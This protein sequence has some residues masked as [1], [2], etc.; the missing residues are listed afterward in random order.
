MGGQVMVA[1]SQEGSATSGSVGLVLSG[2]GARGAY[3]AGALS[4]LLP[5]LTGPD[6]PRVI[7]GSSAGALNAALLASVIDKGVAKAAEN[8]LEAWRRITL[9][10]V[11]AAPRR[12]VVTAATW[13]F[14]H[15]PRTASGLLD[16]TP[17]EKT[18]GE[19]VDTRKI[20]QNV[21]SGLLDSLGIV[22]SS[23]SADDAVVFVEGSESQSP[24][25]GQVRYITTKL[26]I[27]HLLASSAF[28]IAFPPRW[29]QGS[30]AD[31]WYIDGGVHLNTPMKPAID[32]GADR[33]LVLTGTPILSAAHRPPHGSPS[34]GLPPDVTDGNGQI[35]RALLADN[36]ES[37]LTRLKSTNSY[38][39]TAS[40]TVSRGH[41]SIKTFVVGPSDDS[42]SD[43]A[44]R[45]WPAGW[46][47][48]LGS[49][50]GYGLLGSAMHQKQRPGQFLSYLCF[51]PEFIG[52]AIEQG[53][54]DTEAMLGGVTSIPWG[55]PLRTMETRASPVK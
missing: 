5:L 26:G 22:A 11:F 30:G 15:Q 25:S 29:V 7:V 49:L 32:M 16:T 1:Q 33:L 9:E 40:P 12:S 3:E 48:L 17:L 46:K 47:S 19:M 37:D 50:G 45:I 2:A 10:K 27:Q 55:L 28:P 42:L 41:R 14:H 43:V 44:A 35:L 21:Q 23:C 34:P 52:R 31:D 24:A 51:H 8:L 6:S 54:N 36:L 53:R 13:H 4:I 39:A 20:G 18:I 38:L